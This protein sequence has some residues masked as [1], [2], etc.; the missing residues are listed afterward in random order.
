MFFIYFCSVKY[1]P[2]MVM[3]TMFFHLFI[4]DKSIRYAFGLCF[5]V[6]VLFTPLFKQLIL[7]VKQ[8][9]LCKTLIFTPPSTTKQ[10]SLGVGG[11]DF[12]RGC[13]PQSNVLPPNPLT[14][15]KYLI[16]SVSECVKNNSTPMLTK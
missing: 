7:L 8:A 13:F 14:F 15:G 2:K 9:F 10:C 6:W 5:Y 12:Y 4:P 16:E 3:S 1:K 11:D